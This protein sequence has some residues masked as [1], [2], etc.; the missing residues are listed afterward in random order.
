MGSGDVKLAGS[1]GIIFN[2]HI[3]RGKAD[4]KSGQVSDKKIGASHV[5][6]PETYDS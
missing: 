5:E 1:V 4:G 2:T 3:V 6:S